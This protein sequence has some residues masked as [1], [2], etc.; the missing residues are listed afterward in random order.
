MFAL[1][2]LL[3][4]AP[5]KGFWDETVSDNTITV[6]RLWVFKKTFN[7]SDIEYCKARRGGISVYVNGRKAFQIDSMSTNTSNFIK[8]MEK[9]GIEVR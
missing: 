4:V 3:V 9:E 6:S 1:G 5:M 8:R 7:I 2:M